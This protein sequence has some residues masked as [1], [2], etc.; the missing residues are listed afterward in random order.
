VGWVFNEWY[1]EDRAGYMA[2]SRF[3]SRLQ[4]YFD[5]LAVFGQVD[6]DYN[7]VNLAIK[8]SNKEY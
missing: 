7:N 6:A 5:L 3:T 2:Q 1:A 4:G 8:M